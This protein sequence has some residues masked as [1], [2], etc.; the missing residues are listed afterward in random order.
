MPRVRAR[1]ASITVWMFSLMFIALAMREHLAHGGPSRARTVIS[2]S[3]MAPERAE[4]GLLLLQ[5]AAKTLPPYARVAVVK[6][7]GRWDDAGVLAVAHGQL[8]RQHAVPASTIDPGGEP[9]DFVVALD[10]PLADPRFE[11]IYE[12]PAGGIWERVR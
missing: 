10:A 8:P 12:S 6:P 7:N 11:R 1:L 9:P 3:G 5:H 2:H 4:A